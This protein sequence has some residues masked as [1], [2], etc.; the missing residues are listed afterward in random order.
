MIRK[1]KKGELGMGIARISLASQ[2]GPISNFTEYTRR[3]YTKL[4]PS[5]ADDSFA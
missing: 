5:R 2:W 3:N 4:I 1:W